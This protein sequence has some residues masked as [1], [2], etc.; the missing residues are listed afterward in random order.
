MKRSLA[1][2]AITLLVMVYVCGPVFEHFDHWDHFPQS[3]ND[4][5]L[6]FAVVALCLGATFLL[7]RVVL[8]GF[9]SAISFVGSNVQ[10]ALQWNHSGIRILSP[11]PH[12][13]VP[14]RI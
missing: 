12:Q 5:V 14:L 3:G 7:T 10:R 2:T 1:L 8:R 11:P 6:A 13:P 9:G 4:F